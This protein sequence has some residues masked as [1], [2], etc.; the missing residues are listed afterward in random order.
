MAHATALAKT[1]VGA[2]HSAVSIAKSI[3]LRRFTSHKYWN[4]WIFWK[5]ICYQRAKLT[6]EICVH[7]SRVVA[8][9]PFAGMKLPDRTSWGDGDIAPKV[10][11]TYEQELHEVLLQFKSRSYGAVVDVGCAEGYYAIGLAMLNK[12]WRI[13][14]FDTDATARQVCQA[15]AELNAVDDRITIG[16]FCSTKDLGSLAQR[17][18]ALLCVIDCE[19]YELEL[20]T[21]EFIERA[22]CFSDFIIECH[23]FVKTG[24][25]DQL[26][27]RFRKTHT[28]RLIKAGS[29]DPN[30]FDFLNKYD[31]MKRWLAVSEMRPCSMNWL[32]CEAKA[33]SPVIQALGN[34]P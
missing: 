12:R 16:G 21:S 23:D 10:L 30:R 31:D 4:D 24:I 9:G 29:R 18:G 15:A 5:A 32:V 34:G 13:Y 26:Q 8:S 25:T 6:E 19:G 33:E 1:Q 2:A 20:L 17:H 14:A 7:T 22:G 28:V 11:G 3:V 27:D